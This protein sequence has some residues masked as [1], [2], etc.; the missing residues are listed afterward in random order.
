MSKQRDLKAEQINEIKARIQKAASMIIVDYKGLTVAQDTELR[1]EFRAN[2]VSYNVWKNRLVA[3]AL[4]ELGIKGFDEALNGPSA[5]AISENDVVAPAKVLAAK[6]K[7]FKKLNMKC[8]LVEGNYCDRA[9]CDAL[10]AMPNKETLIAMLLGMLQAP[11]AG[12]A[13]AINAIAEQ[14]A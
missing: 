4:D 10:A 1:N 5:F 6:A 2:G 12:F 14:K 3:R 7:A 11:I 13:R 8:G 9:Q